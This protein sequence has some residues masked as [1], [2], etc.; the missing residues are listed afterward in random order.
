MPAMTSVIISESS[1]PSICA[2]FWMISR[3]TPAA[4]RLSFHFFLTDL[5]VRSV[6]DFD[7][8]TR[9]VAATSPVSSSTANR[10]FSIS[11]CG[12]TSEQIPQ[13]WETAARTSSSGQPSASSSSLVLAQCWSGN[14]S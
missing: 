10:T 12:S 13:P 3:L 7:G 8:R 5:A 6:S 1:I 11:L 4:K 2:P 14:C 9:A